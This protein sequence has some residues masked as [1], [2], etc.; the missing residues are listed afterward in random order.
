MDKALLDTDIFSETLKGIDQNVVARAN[1]VVLHKVVPLE[2]LQK[3]IPPA[4][5]T[6]GSTLTMGTSVDGSAGRLG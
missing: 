3:V 2:P 4:E 5:W 1:A 6:A